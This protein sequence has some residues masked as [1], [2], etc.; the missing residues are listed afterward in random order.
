MLVVLI[1]IIITII[2]ITTIIN[3]IINNSNNNNNNLLNFYYEIKYCALSYLIIASSSLSTSKAG[4]I[5]IPTL[6]I[7]KLR[8]RDV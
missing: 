2:I 3:I 1:T 6:Q 4:T 7:R 8:L 5:V